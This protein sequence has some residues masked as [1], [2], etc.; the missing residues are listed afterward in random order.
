M[1]LI[2]QVEWRC[3]LAWMGMTRIAR[4]L[5]ALENCPGLME[6]RLSMRAGCLEN[7][8]SRWSIGSNVCGPLAPRSRTT[9]AEP[10][11]MP[12]VRKLVW[13]LDFGWTSQ[14]NKWN[15]NTINFRLKVCT[16][17]VSF[18]LTVWKDKLAGSPCIFSVEWGYISRQIQSYEQYHS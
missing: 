12:F 1:S 17:L 9:T 8:W 18:S 14:W 2:D 16:D 10:D 4:M 15:I 3:L 6:L 13:Q 11:L 7:W 5:A